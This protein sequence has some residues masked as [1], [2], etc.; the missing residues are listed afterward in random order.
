MFLESIP[1]SIPVASYRHDEN[2]MKERVIIKKRLAE[3]Q[4]SEITDQKLSKKLKVDAPVGQ[5]LKIKG[6]RPEVESEVG[7]EVG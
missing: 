1:I 4:R 7:S 5:R 6:Q 3:S 2:R